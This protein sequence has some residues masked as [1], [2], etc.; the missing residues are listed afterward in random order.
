MLTDMPLINKSPA[1]VKKF[2]SSF[3]I[4]ALL[5]SSSNNVQTQKHRHLLCFKGTG[6]RKMNTNVAGLHLS[7]WHSK[8]LNAVFVLCDT[9]KT[10]KHDI[11]SVAWVRQWIWQMFAKR[12]GCYWCARTAWTVSDI[13][14][15][16]QFWLIVMI[17]VCV[18]VVQPDR[19]MSNVSW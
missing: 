18:T 12:Y 13:E 2:F 8:E 5:Q 17:P 9:E 6:E 11:L 19:S 15:S 7:A 14:T 3:K 4:L 1:D 10:L 16:F